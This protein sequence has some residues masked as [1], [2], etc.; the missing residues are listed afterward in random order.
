[1]ARSFDGRSRFEAYR[2]KFFNE[3]FM[4]LP[5]GMEISPDGLHVIEI[6]VPRPR[7][8]PEHPIQLSPELCRSGHEI[9]VNIIAAAESQ[10]KA[11]E[12]ESRKRQPVTMAE[13][14]NIIRRSQRKGK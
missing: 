8:F 5:S 1:M 10:Q 6:P 14:L 2:L 4:K 12:L 13:M 9:A 3:S 11:L 7:R